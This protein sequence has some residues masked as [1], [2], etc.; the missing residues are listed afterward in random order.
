MLLPSKSN[1]EVKSIPAS[2]LETNPTPKSDFTYTRK[3]DKKELSRERE[4]HNVRHDPIQ[5]SIDAEPKSM[6]EQYRSKINTIPTRRS[7]KS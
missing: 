2:I 5:D 7:D 6:V 4:V 3:D 1:Q